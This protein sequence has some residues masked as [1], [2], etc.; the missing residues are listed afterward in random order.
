MGTAVNLERAVAQ[1][2]LAA[3]KG[4]AQ[5]SYKLAVMYF[6]GHGLP[7]DAAKGLEAMTKAADAGHP[8]AL[9]DLAMIR[10]RGLFGVKPDGPEAMRRLL[11]AAEVGSLDAMQ[12]LVVVYAEGLAGQ[13]KDPV[14]SY[15]WYLVCRRA[16]LPEHML[17]PAGG[18]TA[19]LDDA[20]RKTAEK[21]AEN[22][23]A[24]WEKKQ[25]AGK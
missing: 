23:I 25:A 2:R 20:G 10:L 13:A 21:E 16:G 9:N 19:G 24:A 8:R 4:L 17:P 3:E 1:Y 6:S 18:V 14:K 5:G 12:N 7:K 11:A 15:K 22:W